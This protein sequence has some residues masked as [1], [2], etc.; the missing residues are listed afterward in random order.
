MREKIESEQARTRLALR[1]AENR[2][3]ELAD[4]LAEIEEER[5]QILLEARAQA[6]GNRGCAGGTQPGAPP[7]SRR[8]VSESP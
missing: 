2:R 1:E 3:G 8:R 4:R 7:D 6:S 5:R